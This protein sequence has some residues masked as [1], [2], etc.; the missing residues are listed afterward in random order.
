M[1][2]LFF[3][4]FYRVLFEVKLMTVLHLFPKLREDYLFLG[5]I[6]IVEVVEVNYLLV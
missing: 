5:N 6:Y 4:R 1:L 2:D 3:H